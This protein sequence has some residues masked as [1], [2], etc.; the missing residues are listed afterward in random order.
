VEETVHRNIQML[1]VD[2]CHGSALEVL[3]VAVLF[4]VL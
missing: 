4:N 3:A 1:K 2:Q